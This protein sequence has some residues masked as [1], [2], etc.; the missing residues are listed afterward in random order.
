ML[1]TID[2]TRRFG[3]VT[4]VDAVHIRVAPGELTEVREIVEREMD[5]AIT[6]RVPLEVSAGAGK[7]WDAAAH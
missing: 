2:L 6:L 4:V 1:E 3:E 7:D 5:S